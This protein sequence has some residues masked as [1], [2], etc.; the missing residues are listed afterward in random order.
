MENLAGV[1]GCDVDIE[2]ELTRARINI[3]RHGSLVTHSEVPMTVTGASD[4]FFSACLYTTARSPKIGPRDP[5]EGSYSFVTA[6][7]T[8]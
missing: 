4:A 7:R 6:F 3:V 8:L 5:W 1:Q 2:R